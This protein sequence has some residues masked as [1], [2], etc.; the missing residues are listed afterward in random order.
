MAA[1][2]T[3]LH[4]LWVPRQVEIDKQR[5]ELKVDAFRSGFGSDENALAILEGFDDGGLH[6]GGFRA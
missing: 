1:A 5:T 3:L 6:V 4:T 2:N